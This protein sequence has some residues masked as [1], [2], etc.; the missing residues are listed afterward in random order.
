MANNPFM[1]LGEKWKERRAEVTPGLSPNRVRSNKSYLRSLS[2]NI[3]NLTP[4]F[5]ANIASQ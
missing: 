3:F 2:S 5:S 1:L 4:G